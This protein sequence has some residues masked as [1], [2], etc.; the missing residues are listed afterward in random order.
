MLYLSFCN[1][2]SLFGFFIGRDCG[3]YVPDLFFSSNFKNSLAS[4]QN[5]DVLL[6][7]LVRVDFKE[8]KGRGVKIDC[9]SSILL[10]EYFLIINML[11]NEISRITKSL[12]PGMLMV[13]YHVWW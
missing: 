11:P 13:Y 7:L 1:E 6:T 12:K 2:Q 9:F 3:K 4:E 8:F 10:L 5:L